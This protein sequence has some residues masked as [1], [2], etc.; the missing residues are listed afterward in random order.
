MQRNYYAINGFQVVRKAHKPSK[1]SHKICENANESLGDGWMVIS[2]LQNLGNGP[3][4]R[5][6]PVKIGSNHFACE[7]YWL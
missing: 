5:Q 3:A 7:M 4:R 1:E 6:L 2:K